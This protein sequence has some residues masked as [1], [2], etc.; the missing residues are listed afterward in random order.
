MANTKEDERRIAAIYELIA[1]ALLR[2]YRKEQGD[3]A[4]HRRVRQGQH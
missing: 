4:H 2:K 1:K 3:G